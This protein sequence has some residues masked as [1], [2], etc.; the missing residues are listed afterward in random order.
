MARWFLRQPHYLEIEGTEWEHKEVSRESGKQK[1]VRYK[2]PMF[3]NPEDPADYNYPEGIIVAYEGKGLPKD[4]IF[5]G[6]PTPDMEPL[7]D[8]AKAITAECSKSWVHPIESL[9]GQGG[10]GEK[11]LEDFLREMQAMRAASSPS[12]PLSAKGASQADVDELKAQ[13]KML[14]EQLASVK[15]PEAPASERRV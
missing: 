7:D 11:L 12:S 15:A 4:L 9:P 2:V 5:T 14:T 10:F 8:E 13:V 6:K 1:T 3:L